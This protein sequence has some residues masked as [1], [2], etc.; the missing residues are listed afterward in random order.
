MRV[1]VSQSK[2]QGR[3]TLLRVLFL[4]KFNPFT[5]TKFFLNHRHAD[6]K[7]LFPGREEARATLEQL[8][9]L[10]PFVSFSSRAMLL[11]TRK[12]R[13]KKCS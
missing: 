12:V 10:T 4:Y 8:S 7:T 1:C 11:A 5:K 3:E 2:R 6:D 9:T 13:A